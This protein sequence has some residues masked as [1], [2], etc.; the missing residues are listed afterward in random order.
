M[1][2]FPIEWWPLTEWW[3]DSRELGGDLLPSNHSMAVYVRALRK[4]TEGDCNKELLCMHMGLIIQYR[5]LKFT[6]RKSQSQHQI[7]HFLGIKT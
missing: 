6:G 5:G 2:G 1:I 3:D 4:V 7:V